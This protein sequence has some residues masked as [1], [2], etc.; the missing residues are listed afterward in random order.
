METLPADIIRYIANE[1]LDNIQELLLRR[2][3]RYLRKCLPLK[4]GDT[5]M[6]YHRMVDTC[7]DN[8]VSLFDYLVREYSTLYHFN[9]SFLENDAQ[10][11]IL[12]ICE[13][14]SVEML[15]AFQKH[16]CETPTPKYVLQ[17][18]QFGGRIWKSMEMY[19]LAS[20]ETRW[21]CL[22]VWSY[23][24]DTKQQKDW[25]FKHGIN[26]GFFQT[27]A[28]QK[29][30]KFLFAHVMDRYSTYISKYF[31]IP[32]ERFEERK[33]KKRTAEECFPEI[34]EPFDPDKETITNHAS[35]IWTKNKLVK[36]E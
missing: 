30:D 16:F 11:V 36:L 33:T 29:K 24:E 25:L 7:D 34:Y 31:N 1:F 26:V 12:H 23:T 14:D 10:Y 5:K 3:S 21:H 22:D 32:T 2:S 17:F 13:Q 15:Y 20:F 19:M 8:N 27:M 9:T 28:K 18:M 4:N 6:L 35:W